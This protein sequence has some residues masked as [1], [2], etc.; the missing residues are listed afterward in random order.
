MTD[1]YCQECGYRFKALKA[2]EKASFGDDGCPRCGGCDV[3]L[4]KPKQPEP[5]PGVCS[6]DA[7]WME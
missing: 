1:F 2:A 3:D 4:G 6:P 7:A 5:A